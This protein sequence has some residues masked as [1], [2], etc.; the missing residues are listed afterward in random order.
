MFVVIDVET[1]GLDAATDRLVEIAAVRVSEDG[2]VTDRFQSLVNPERSIPARAAQVHGITTGMVYDAPPE[3]EV[4][5][6]YLDF[7]G[8]GVL[9]AHNL[10]FDQGFLDAALERR[11]RPTLSGD[12][13][14]TLRLARRLLPG[15][16]KHTLGALARFYEIETD[17]QH[18]AASDAQITAVVLQKFLRQLD[19]EHEIEAL[20]D[21]LVFQYKT[22]RQVRRPPKALRR[23]RAEVLPQVPHAPGV[24]FLENK[25]GTPHY[26]GKARDL[27]RRVG[28][29]LSG[30]ESASKRQRRLVEATREV[31]W[32][33]TPSEL[34]A[35]L[36]E[37]HLIKEKKPRFNRA[38]RRYRSRPFL[39]LD[40]AEDFPRLSWT[41]RLNAG[42]DPDGDAVEYYGPLAGRE[43][44]EDLVET[45][46]RFFRLRECDDE[47]FRRGERCLYADIDRC[48]A[49]C[50]HGAS[51][52]GHA[53]YA[54]AVAEV[55][56]FLGGRDPAV[57]EQAETKMEMASEQLDFERA[58]EE[59]DALERLERFFRRQRFVG[60]P[61]RSCDAVLLLPEAERCVLYVVRHGLLRQTLVVG[62]S[63]AAEARAAVGEALA[64]HFDPEAEPPVAFTKRQAHEARLL[65]QWTY[66][67]REEV[68][69]VRWD[70]EPPEALAER[71]GE[72]VRK[73]GERMKPPVESD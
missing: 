14:C 52:E 63:S 19:F 41:Y 3:E 30:I 47:R 59:R 27:R 67:R 45:L 32:E 23:L 12:T 10:S 44:A 73:E 62:P 69:Q 1:T 37:S 57:L 29:H 16:G 26:I 65:Q 7:L 24:Y 21:I 56:A 38:G 2:E 66:R 4:L 64:R 25:S 18:R 70:G 49:P 6:R 9:T 61:V 40:R 55:R 68:Q 22:Y 42:D 20:E 5:P 48:P 51:E 15:L 43:A 39:R 46:G 35:L 50:E 11:E 31:S 72:R 28:S 13:L 36:R 71:V 34:D 58:A 8:D 54:E 60:G 33:K 17:E 53:A